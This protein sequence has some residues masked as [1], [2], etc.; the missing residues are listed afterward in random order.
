MT[1]RIV[2]LAGGLRATLVHQPQATRAA[3]MARVSAGSHH[4]PPRF[5]GLAHLLEHLLF[6]GSERYR[7]DDRLMAWV[8]RQGGNVNATTLARHSAFFF[9]VAA[10]NLSDGVARLRDMLQAPLLSRLDIQREVAVIDA[11]NR[12]IQQHDAARREAA[13]RHAMEQP[14][15]FR[16]FQVG[17]HDSLGQDT[18][19][20]HAALRDFH[21]RYYVAGHLQLWLQGPQTLDAL[22][23]LAHTFATGFASGGVPEA[24]SPLRLSAE[25]DYQLAVTERPALWRC[26]LIRKSD[27]VTLLREFLLDEAPGSLIDGLRA[28]GLAEEVSLDWLYQDDDYG[29]L[30]L[31]LDGERPEA[32]D[33]QITRW[34]RALQQTTQEQ[35]R[36]YYRLAQ[37]RFS[38]LSAL[39]QLRQRAFGFAPGAAPVDFSAFCAD[40][41]AAPTSYLACKKM[42]AAGTISSQGFALPLSHW[43][44]QPVADES[45]IAF[46]FYPQAAQYS[47]PALTPEAVP[48]LHLPAQAQAPT[49][50]LR[51]PFYSRVSESQ[52]VAIGKQLRPLLAEMRHIG[53]SGEWQTVDGSWQLTLRLPDAV[54]MAEPIIGAIIDRLSRPTPAIT[55]APDGIAIRQLLK[56]LPERLASEPSRNG[57]LAALAG[58]SAGHAHGLARQL[59]LLRAPVNAKPLPLSDCPGGVEHIPHASEDSALLVFIPLPPG[60]SLAALRLLAL[61]CEPRFFQRLRVEQ[62]IG[63]VVSCRYQRIADRDGLLLALQ[64]PDR[65]PVNLLGCCKRFLRELTLCDESEFS[66]LR[67][68][69]ATQIRS[70]MDASAT[71]VAA[72]RQRYGLPVLT[73]QAIDAL[74]PDEIVALWREMTRRRRRWRV[75]FTG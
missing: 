2:E 34:L 74:Q 20:L 7:G 58:G 11:E 55:P 6:R 36:H 68:Q 47:A 8:Q 52:G 44:R 75:L 42:E 15:V 71:A 38:A 49:L 62:Q 32:I 24:A 29:W 28:R 46:S 21:R 23:E 54:V 30:A 48:L 50:I 65:S 35:Q 9:E 31:T 37:Q 73:P 4:E 63:Y 17:S 13:A 72:L 43:R 22:A 18:G 39:D 57:W 56:Q 3:A 69:L 53:G 64:S 26:P 19:S 70:P 1:I 16:R 12:L 51:K 41:L 5:A 14:E 45:P 40:L 60:A 61:C 10:E 66:L 59:G 67:Q 27:N 33:A 25:A